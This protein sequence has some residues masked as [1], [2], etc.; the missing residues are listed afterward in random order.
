MNPRS[1]FRIGQHPVHPMLVP[2]V[3]AFYIGAFGA[4][5]GFAVSG[6][7]FWARGALWLMGAG[8]VASAFAAI[9]GLIDFLYEPAIRA[10]KAAWWH[11]GGNVLM[12]LVSIMDWALRYPIGAEAGSHAYWP[13]SLVAVLLLVFNG[14][15]GGELVYCH[16]VGVRD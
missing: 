8:I 2:F 6:D 12:A 5:I 7:P 3:I 9:A 13:L 15:K 14:W 10:L 16:R 11:F 4:D 1:S